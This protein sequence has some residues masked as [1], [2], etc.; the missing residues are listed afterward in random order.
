MIEA[1]Q[2]ELAALSTAF[3]TALLDATKAYSR[4]LSESA[5]VAGLPESARAMMAAGARS[6]GL[7]GAGGKE[8]SAEAGP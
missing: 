4:V 2:T 7:T 5:Q 1:I 6:R 8:A 3:S